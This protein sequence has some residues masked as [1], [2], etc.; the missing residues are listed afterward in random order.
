MKYCVPQ[1]CDDEKVT[2]GAGDLPRSRLSGFSVSEA[3]R[4]LLIQ[5]F[6]QK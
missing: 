4:L 5:V 6:D 1:S 2:R 3:V